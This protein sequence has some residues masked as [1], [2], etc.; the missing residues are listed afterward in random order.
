LLRLAG[1]LGSDVPLFLLGGTALGVGRGSEVYPLP[2]LPRLRGL[3]VVP[4]ERISTAEAYAA[5][6][7]GLTN[8]AAGNMI[9]S[10]QS[11]VW[12]AGAGVSEEA[13]S[14]LAGNDF[15]QVVF[16]QHPRLQTIKTR[17]RRH[18]AASAMLTGS[19]SGIYGL[20]PAPRKLEA[21]LQHFQKELAFPFAFVSRDRYRACWRRRLRPHI[22]QELWPPQS[23]DAR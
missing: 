2:D 10:F 22:D 21:A 11:C 6:G 13:F 9:N 15:E 23:R 12:S 14:A 4:E 19:G 1:E 7:R 8:A 20:F 17:L 3:L 5:L 16:R 18:G